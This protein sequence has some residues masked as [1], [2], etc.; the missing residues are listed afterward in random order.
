[1]AAIELTRVARR[2]GPCVA[3]ADI[4]FDAE[5]G[6]IVAVVGPHGA[7]KSTLLRLLGG[8]LAP[9]VGMVRISGCVA[10]SR[11]ARLLTGYAADPPLPPPELT[12]WEWLHY[13]ASQHARSASHRQVLVRYAASVAGIGG[14][15]HRRIAGYPREAAQRLAVAAAAMAGRSL[16]LL[17]EVLSGLDP[18]V[19]REVQ[20]A[21]AALARA[22]RVVIVASHDLSTLE[23]V[24]TR[25]LVLWE[26]RL[27]ADV[28]TASL[29]GE[30]IAELS[31]T[32]GAL[33]H[34]A[35]LLTRF[36]GAV[37]TGG[38]VA[39]PLLDGLTIEGLLADCRHLRIP[40]AGSRVRYRMLDDLFMSATHRATDGAGSTP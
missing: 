40:V 5:A 11:A 31:L 1:M 17:D 12:G 19:T 38:G 4:S 2:F 30:R 34:T 28:Q 23:R 35:P 27:V 18:I 20:D 25:V 16:L 6:D 8:A 29:L 7:G 21:L 10:G 39:V 32:G 13:V 26:G 14:F 15:A 24:A 37:R 3:L 36:R 9:S 22:G 33:A